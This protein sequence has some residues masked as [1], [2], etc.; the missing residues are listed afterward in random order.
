MNLF[1]FLV[2]AAGSDTS[3]RVL[4]I[5]VERRLQGLGTSEMVTF[6]SRAVTCDRCDATPSSTVSSTE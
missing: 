1:R 4:R 2:A 6:V 3:I 5:A